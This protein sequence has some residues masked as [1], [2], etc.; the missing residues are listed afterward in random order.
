[1]ANYTNHVLRLVSVLQRALHTSPQAAGGLETWAV[2]FRVKSRGPAISRSET[3]R[4]LALLEEQISFA[5]LAVL[6]AG[7][8]KETVAP[9]FTRIRNAIAVET[10]VN[11]GWQQVTSQLTSN[12]PLTPLRVAGEMIGGVERVL[13][14]AD[15]SKI[16]AALDA[17]TQAVVQLRSGDPVRTFFEAQLQ[18]LERARRE[19]DIAGG[20]ALRR[21]F[22]QFEGELEEHITAVRTDGGVKLTEEHR[23]VVKAAVTVASCVRT[24]M[25]TVGLVAALAAGA[26]SSLRLAGIAAQTQMFYL[27][28]GAP[29]A[30]APE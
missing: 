26:E 5:E 13:S 22:H 4:A 24:A 10:V 18:V 28:P 9:S 1:M 6:R 7:V 16:D 21:T 19:Y 15:L 17:L 20:D 2:V 29:P 3:L 27:N 25:A 8:R 23:A 11:G 30:E 12:D 14:D